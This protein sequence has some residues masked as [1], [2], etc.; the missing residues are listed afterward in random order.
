MTAARDY[1][2]V[3]IGMNAAG[4]Q[5]ASPD[6]LTR[7]DGLLAVAAA[8]VEREAPGAPQPVKNE[9]VVR[10]AGYL[11][12]SDFGGIRREVIGPKEAEYAMNHAPAFRSCGAKGLLS[13]W[14][15]RRAR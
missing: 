3:Q 7:L 8:F 10:F 9:A 6:L 2:A 12:Q 5:D 14:K 11:R 15:R 4:T 13:P 1:L